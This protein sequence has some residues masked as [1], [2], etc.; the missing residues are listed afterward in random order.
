VWSAD[1]GAPIVDLDHGSPVL[2]AIW[3]PD[4]ERIATSTLRGGLHVWSADGRGEP[5]E[6]ESPAPVI[7]MAFLDGGRRILAVAADDTT[8][9]W[10]I[11]V[12]ALRRGLAATNA[13]CLPEA[14]RVTYLGESR[15]KA[16]EQ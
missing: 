11:D 5:V 14:M 2:C 4:G 6:I 3:S 7:A 10:T 9:T 13:D 16:R 15:E 1:G 12:G 8:R